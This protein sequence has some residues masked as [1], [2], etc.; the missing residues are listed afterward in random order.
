MDLKNKSHSAASKSFR[1]ASLHRNTINW[2]VFIL[3]S[4][5]LLITFNTTVTVIQQIW[6]RGNDTDELLTFSSMVQME[7]GLR[8]WLVKPAN[9]WGNHEH[10]QYDS[11]I[12]CICDMAQH[13]L[14]SL[15]F[16]IQIH[17]LSCTDSF[18]HITCEL[19]H[20]CRFAAASATSLGPTPLVR[21]AAAHHSKKRNHLHCLKSICRTCTWVNSKED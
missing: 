2:S 10:V 12:I 19:I 1:I 8:R 21:F 14:E 9:K 16:L 17:I 18:F 20:E 15:I 7:R 4:Y 13:V 3:Y 11:S 6:F 5:K